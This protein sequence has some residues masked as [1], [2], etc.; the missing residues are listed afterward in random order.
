[1]DCGTPVSRV[2]VS[3]SNRSTNQTRFLTALAVSEV[4]CLYEWTTALGK[5]SIGV[6]DEEWARAVGPLFAWGP[7]SHKRLHIRE[8]TNLVLQFEA[9]P[10]EAFK[11]A[12]AGVQSIGTQVQV[13]DRREGLRRGV[14]PVIVIG[15]HRKK[16][17]ASRYVVCVSR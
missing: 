4:E 17:G 11:I 5:P 16:R 1:M 2:G 10:R 8:P 15:M 14:L 6:D 9:F 12:E 3:C 13:R 7:Q